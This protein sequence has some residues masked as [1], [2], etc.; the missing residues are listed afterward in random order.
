MIA[1]DPDNKATI[2]VL[3]NLENT[4][5]INVELDLYQKLFAQ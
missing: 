4:N 5:V 2:I 3:S 1:R